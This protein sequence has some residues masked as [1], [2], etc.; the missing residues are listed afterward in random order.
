[1]T[2]NE[3]LLQDR[4]AKIQS[5]M[6]QYGEENFAISFSGGKDSTVIHEL[7]DMALP[8]NTIPRVYAD[9]GIE[10]NMIRDFVKRKAEKDDRI[11]IISPSKPIK[12][13]LEAVGYPF[14]SKRHSHVL[15]IYQRANYRQGMKS[16]E[17][18]LGIAQ[19]GK[20]YSS[21][22][23]C[24]K[25]LRYQFSPDFKL[26]ISDRCCVEMKEKP[27]DKWQKEHNKPYAVIGLMASEGGRRDGAKCLAFYG[28]KLKAFQPLAPMTKDWED[29]FIDEYGIEIADI[30]KPPYNFTRTGCKGCPF[31]IHLQQALDT[32]EQYFP[33]ERRQ[34]EIIW[35]PVYDEYRRL[36]YRLRKAEDDE[37]LPG[38]IEMEEWLKTL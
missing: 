11:V 29:W 13:T 8:G 10:L 31:N 35:K 37:Q 7:F 26:Y 20:Q 33:A 3:F 30:Y 22:R 2:E 28:G 38:Q 18:Y 15:G 36:G 6:K 12:Q 16:I 23:S 9:T 19:D 1:M 14:K 25:I 32:L 5:V 4:I 21:E 17:H 34:C 24:P 27:L